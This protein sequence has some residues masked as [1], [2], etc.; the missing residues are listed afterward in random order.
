V[1]ADGNLFIAERW[2]FVIRRVD[3]SGVITTVA[4]NGSIGYSGDGGAATSAELNNPSGVAVDTA[5]NLFIADTY[6]NVIREAAPFGIIT[7]VAGNGQ[8]GYSGDGG[9]ATNAQLNLP[10][11]T[12]VDATG[13][14][15]IADTANHRIREV[16][17]L[18]PT[19]V[20]NN[21]GF[22]NAGAYDVVVSNPYGSVT[23]SVVNVT[24]TL[25]PVIL[26]APRMTPGQASF[27]FQLS[28][29]VG[30]NY[31]LQVSTNLLNWN[32]VSTSTIPVSGSI[33]LSNPV[34]GYNRSF[35]R[36]RLQ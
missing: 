6:N 22:G 4:G 1:D 9:A 16:I 29:P 24:V 35:Y 2:N 13:N 34:S 19:L 31:V 33:T 17:I 28:G 27:N 32:P 11:S 8:G 15:F 30:S 12:A 5:G 3:T 18:G 7:T 36:V 21:A 25:P 10:F 14:L 20:L 26:S 23:S